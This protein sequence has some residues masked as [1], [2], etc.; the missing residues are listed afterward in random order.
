MTK[1]IINGR[2]LIHR[3]TGVERFAREIVRELDEIVK[4]GEYEIACPPETAEIIEL[5]N[6]R[7]V[8]IGRLHNQLWE[9]ISF[10][11]YV[12]A[13]TRISELPTIKSVCTRLSLQ[14]KSL[15]SLSPICRFEV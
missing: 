1:I 8:K 15:G 12:S 11:L 14:P 9:H 6:I 10:P 2:F 5:K 4:P 3:I 13:V 7:V